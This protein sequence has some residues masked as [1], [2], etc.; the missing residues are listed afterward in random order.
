MLAIL[1]LNKVIIFI[2]YKYF[3]IYLTIMNIIIIKTEAYIDLTHVSI[4]IV[5]KLQHIINYYIKYVIHTS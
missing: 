3:T 4:F 1:Y 5:N 2:E